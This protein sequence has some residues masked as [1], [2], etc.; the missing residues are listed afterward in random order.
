M[1][2]FGDLLEDE[3]TH[4]Y[5]RT[6]FTIILFAEHQENALLNMLDAYDTA[7]LSKTLQYEK[8]RE[9]VAGRPTEAAKMH[10]VLGGFNPTTGE[11]KKLD[12]ETIRALRKEGYIT[13][14]QT[15]TLN[16][17]VQ[18]SS[19]TEQ[20][21][22]LEEHSTTISPEEKKDKNHGFGIPSLEKFQNGDGPQKGPPQA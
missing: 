1:C 20:S 18:S 3:G 13:D 14:K 19:L 16:T 5:M 6:L 2:P 10:M 12:S 4:R 7:Q 15:A 11:M 21:S 17:K 9:L 8:L 22:M